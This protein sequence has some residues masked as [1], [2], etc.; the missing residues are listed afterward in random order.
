MAQCQDRYC[1]YL[2][3]IL[4]LQNFAS[5]LLQPDGISESDEDIQ[6][7][8]PRR[9]ARNQAARRPIIEESSETDDET[10]SEAET[11][12]EGDS[13]NEEKDDEIWCYCNKSEHGEMA[14]CDNDSCIFRWFHF[15]C[16]GLKVPSQGNWTCTA[17]ARAA[18]PELAGHPEAEEVLGGNIHCLC[19]NA[20]FGRMVK[21]D[22]Q[23]CA[24]KWF[25]WDCVGLE[26]RPEYW[27]CPSCYRESRK[28]FD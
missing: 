14:A 4:S 12:N 27:F 11:D 7:S 22:N 9:S 10:S 23:G 16:V 13:G 24:M 26:M 25:H 21:C 2:S 8:H 28:L 6:S 5:I 20:G 19:R 3:P 15:D 1:K 17:C 18:G